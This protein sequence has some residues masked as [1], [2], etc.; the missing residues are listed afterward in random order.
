MHALRDKVE[1]KRSRQRAEPC[2]AALGSS[3]RLLLC[4][5]VMPGRVLA[6]PLQLTLGSNLGLDKTFAQIIGFQ[7]SIKRCP[8]QT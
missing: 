6:I 4:Y 1:V 8:S 5:S 7:D 2:R 3:S